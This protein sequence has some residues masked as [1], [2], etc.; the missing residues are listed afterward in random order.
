MLSPTPNPDLFLARRAASGLAD[1]WDAGVNVFTPPDGAWVIAYVL[2][3]VLIAA[4]CSLGLVAR[5]QKVGSR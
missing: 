2:V 3:G 1:A 4:A 5:F